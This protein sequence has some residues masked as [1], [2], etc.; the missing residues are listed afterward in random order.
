MTLKYVERI[1]NITRKM[2]T[3][4]SWKK[5]INKKL[6]IKQLKEKTPSHGSIIRKQLTAC[7]THR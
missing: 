6:K 3:E 7:L 4:P 2:D 1:G 5:K